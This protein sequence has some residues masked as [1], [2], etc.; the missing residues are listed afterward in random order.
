VGARDLLRQMRGAGFELAVADGKLRVTP[1][2]A[3]TDDLRTALRAC[4]PE[5]LVLLSDLSAVVNPDRQVVV[6]Q[7][8][9]DC[10]HLLRHGTCGRPVEAGLLTEEE[11]FGIV[12]PTEEYGASCPAF[13]SKV[14]AAAD[15][16]TDPVDTVGANTVITATLCPVMCLAAY[17]YEVPDDGLMHGVPTREST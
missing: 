7:R 8:C 6:T 10:L 9:A 2:S 15:V 5:L 11:G 14:P 4:K 12:W 1:A 3:L 16:Q 13:T 17:D